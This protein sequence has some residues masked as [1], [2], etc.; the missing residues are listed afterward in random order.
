MGEANV[1]VLSRYHDEFG[2]R[3]GYSDHTP[4]T[5]AALAAVALGAVVIEKHLTLDT[6]MEGPDHSSSLDPE[7]FREYVAA[8]RRVEA[9]LGTAEKHVTPSEAGNQPLIRKGL[10]AKST[11]IA[12]EE[13]SM[14]NVVA[15]RPVATAP[16]SLW[17]EVKGRSATRNYAPDE[18]LEVDG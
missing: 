16:A 8:L 17:P 15:K 1:K 3:V 12:G 18:P 14:E 4:S 2:C 10:Y 11:I 5:E 13:F 9:A 7:D 6:T